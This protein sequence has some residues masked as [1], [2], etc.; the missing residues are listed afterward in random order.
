[1]HL[2]HYD[3][4]TSW[5]GSLR[6]ERNTCPSYRLGLFLADPLSDEQIQ[7]LTEESQQPGP[8]PASR[9]PRLDDESRLVVPK[10]VLMIRVL[11]EEDINK[12][13]KWMQQSRRWRLWSDPRL[14]ICKVICISLLEGGGQLRPRVFE[15]HVHPSLRRRHGDGISTKILR[16]HTQVQSPEVHASD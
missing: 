2:F 15:G 3:C 8:E 1:M 10:E 9:Q 14:P 11:A 4:I 7:Q 5:H 13:V 12:V 6:P 16:G